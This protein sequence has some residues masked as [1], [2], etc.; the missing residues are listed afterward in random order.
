MFKISWK[1][2]MVLALTLGIGGGSAS[3]IRA[4][5]ETELVPGNYPNQCYYSCGGCGGDCQGKN[6]I[7]CKQ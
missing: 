1:K 2:M 4:Q 5:T 7:C 3:V 6:Y